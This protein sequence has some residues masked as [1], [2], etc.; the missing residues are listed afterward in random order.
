MPKDNASLLFDV[1]KR[2]EFCILPCL[3]TTVRL[4]LFA[5]IALL[6]SPKAVSVPKTY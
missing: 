3:C 6:G 5:C 4:V 1:F 2:T